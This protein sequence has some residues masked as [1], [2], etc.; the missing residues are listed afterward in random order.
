MSLARTLA[1]MR[2][3]PFL[4]VLGDEALKLLA[5]GSDPVNLRARQSL[6]DAGDDANGAVLVMGG[7]L[8]LIPATDGSSPQVYSVGR[9]VDELALI[10]PSQRTATA[11]A[12][13]S[14]EIIPLQRTQ[15]LRIL[16]EYP[17]AARRLQAIIA[18]RNATFLADVE[19]VSSRLRH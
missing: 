7:Q 18:R 9:L 12:Q 16:D 3:V 10:I 15:M 2:N 17:A 14:C 8:R 19:G 13:T 11:I 5:F 6:F 4:S 1:V